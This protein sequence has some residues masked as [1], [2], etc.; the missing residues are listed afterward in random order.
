MECK[1]SQ[2]WMSAYLDAEL[3]ASATLQLEMHLAGC[4]QC[5]A[6]LAQLQALR[7]TIAQQ[8]TR[9][10]A[11]E[12]LK[13]R[14]NTAIGEQRQLRRS[15]APSARA[16]TWFGV[17]AASLGA[18][19]FAVM[20]ALYLQQ[21]PRGEQLDQELVA[22]HVRALMP[23]HLADVASTDQHTVKPW[24]AGKLDFSPPVVDLAAQ[25]YALIG[26]RL[27]YLNQ[28]PVAALVYQHRKHILNLYV[29]PVAASDAAPRASSRQGFQVLRWRQDG[30]QYS[31]V[32]DMN[33]Q[34]L[35]E[36]AQDLRNKVSATTAQEKRLPTQ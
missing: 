24:F 25:G 2:E 18:T 8:A 14:I 16:S 22:S 17:G 36:F 31:A 15:R 21:P 10:A 13:H 35:S 7:A 28:R 20:L 6:A 19:A 32:S 30:M 1:H 26:G 29:W 11:P 4:K 3:D 9:H 23:D 34:E 33:A 27:D 5:E 12:Y